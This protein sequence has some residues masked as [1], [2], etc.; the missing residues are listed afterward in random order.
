MKAVINTTP[1]VS[2]AAID[3]LCLLDELFENVYIPNVVFKEP[4]AI[5]VYF[6]EDFVAKSNEIE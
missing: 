6:K 4:D 1:L 5:Y 2:L 3:K